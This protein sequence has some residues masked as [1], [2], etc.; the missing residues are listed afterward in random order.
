M[1]EAPTNP[2]K[3]NKITRQSKVVSQDALQRQKVLC[4]ARRKAM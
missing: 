2:D 1:Q 4:Y 3:L